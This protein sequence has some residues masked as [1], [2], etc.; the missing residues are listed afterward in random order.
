MVAAFGSGKPVR[1]DRWLTR[2]PRLDRAML[3]RFG[4]LDPGMKT[5][6]LIRGPIAEASEKEGTGV[7]AA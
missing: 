1:T 7:A 2:F 5:D 3:A 6:W 4:A